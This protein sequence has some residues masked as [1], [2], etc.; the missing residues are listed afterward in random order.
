VPKA[1]FLV[2]LFVNWSAAEIHEKGQEVEHFIQS[3]VGSRADDGSRPYSEVEV[4]DI[5]FNPT[6]KKFPKSYRVCV[7]GIGAGY[8]MNLRNDHNSNNVY[9]VITKDGLRQKCFCRCDTLERRAS[10]KC[11]DFV[12]K[13]FPLPEGLRYKLFGTAR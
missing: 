11:K 6:S 9:F 1:L 5:I 3:N 8:C 13:P 10:G 7:R 12:S 2:E 4:G